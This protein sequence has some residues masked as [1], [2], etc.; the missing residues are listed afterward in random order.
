MSHFLQLEQLDGSISLLTIDTPDKKVNTLGE[1]VLRELSDVIGQ[2]EQ[3]AGVRGLL[4]RSGKPGQFIAGADLHELGGLIH[5]T[6]DERREKLAAGHGLF[7]RISRLPFPTVAL[8]DGNCMGGGTE[9]VLAMDA[10][11]ASSTS[12]TKIALPETT[13]GLIPG[14]GGTQRMPRLIGIHHAIDMICGGQPVSAQRAAELG[15]VFDAVP[16]ERLVDEGRR[17]IEQFIETEQWKRDRTQRSQ[18]FGL[19]EDQFNFAFACA[20]GGVKAKTKGQYPAPLAALRA[21][22]E[23]INLPLEE[24]LQVERDISMEVMGSEISANLIGVFFMQNA[25]SRDR[26]VE[27]DVAARTVNQVGVLGAGLM[28]AGIATAHARSAVSTTLVDVDNDRIA[29][30]LGSAR[31]VVEGRIKIGRAT[32]EDLASMLQMLS[33]STSQQSFAGC[34]VVVEAVPE[35]EELKTSVYKS[36]AGVMRE[37]A[38]LASNTSTISIT[39]MAESSPNP[40][41]FVGMHFFYPVDRMGLVEVIRGE[42]TSDETV[43]TIVELARRIKKTPIVCNDCPGFLVNR[44]LLPYMNE[45]LLMLTEGAS[46]DH[47]DKVATRF[48]LPMGPIALHDLVGLDTACSA[49]KVMVAGFA[50]RA[51]QSPLLQAMVDAGRLGKKSG[52]GFR[53]YVG[54]KQTP[55]LDADFDTLLDGHRTDQREF[56]DQEIQDRLLLPMLLEA[57]RVYEEEIVSTPSHVD[58]GLILGIGFPPFRGGLFRWCDQ[59][60]C[61]ALLESASQYELGPRFVPNLLLKDMA[62]AG[63]KFYEK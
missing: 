35:N 32:P 45:S 23:G 51:V 42:K 26:G 7:D 12:K 60:G 56:S 10:R 49:G 14:W 11:I 6:P 55:A 5:A 40:E 43:A 33:T 61:R 19:S 63:V 20:E 31:K 22:K 48:G 16:V 1:T 44:I 54:K 47:I 62:R 29:A 38:I 36:L 52:A 34:D 27:S 21:I 17:L 53:K 41:R 3:D 58:M 4:F 57:S 2:L 8:I 50:D 9:L 28:G 37:D 39:R 15:L 13:I 18:P 59:P 30:G 25:L 24:G 46:M